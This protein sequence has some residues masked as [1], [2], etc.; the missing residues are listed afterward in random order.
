MDLEPTYEELKLAH[1]SCIEKYLLNLEPTYE[2]L[3]RVAYARDGA[4]W[5]VFRAYLWGIETLK[6]DGSLDNGFENLEPTY[7]ELKLKKQST[8]N[9]M[10]V[11][12]E[13]TYEELKQ[14]TLKAS[15]IIASNLEPT[16]EE[17]KPSL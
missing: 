3:K 1:Q 12:L 2:E 6:E 9:F 13:P 7:E 15:S 10:R 5:Y 14:G 17:L 8:I 11:N 4:T 16:Y